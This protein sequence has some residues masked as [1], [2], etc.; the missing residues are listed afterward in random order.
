MGRVVI[1]RKKRC[2]TI[3]EMKNTL[4]NMLPK[5]KYGLLNEEEKARLFDYSNSLKNRSLK[6]FSE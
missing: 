6:T 1:S 5:P 3:P 2:K 4:R